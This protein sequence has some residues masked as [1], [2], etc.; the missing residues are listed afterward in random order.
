MLNPIPE[1][2]TN[3]VMANIRYYANSNPD[4]TKAFRSLLLID[5]EPMLCD[6][7]GTEIAETFP[8]L[9][10]G[11]VRESQAAFEMCGRLYFDVIV[12]D[13]RM[14]K[15]PGDKLIPELRKQTPT[16]YIIAMTSFGPE[17]AFLAGKADPDEFYQKGPRAERLLKMVKRGVEKAK[18]RREEHDWGNYCLKTETFLNI[19]D[20]EKRSSIRERVGYSRRD[21]DDMRKATRAI[22]AL[23]IGKPNSEALEWSGFSKIAIMDDW[24]SGMSCVKNRN[25]IF[26]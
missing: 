18:S 21:Y 4:L 23:K 19:Q 13:I 7:L 16:S 20:N 22:Y 11:C 10:V 15:I 2:A 6:S 24:L 25:T 5:D 8:N 3:S 14:P 1:A 9:L 12:S 17:T 26:Y